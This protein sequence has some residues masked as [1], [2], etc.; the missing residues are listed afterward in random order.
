MHPT[1]LL[2][3]QDR[4]VGVVPARSGREGAA[5][6]VAANGLGVDGRQPRGGRQ[7]RAGSAVDDD[8]VERS[9]ELVAR[10]LP[11]E[12][13][14]APPHDFVHE[15]VVAHDLVEEQAHEVRRAPVDV[16]PDGAT[17]RQKLH[18]LL[19]PRCEHVQVRAEPIAPAVVVG[20]CAHHPP[21]GGTVQPCLV[22]VS[23]LRPERGIEVDQIDPPLEAEAA[24]HIERV[25]LHETPDGAG[26][27]R[28][29]DGATRCRCPPARRRGHRRR[30]AKPPGLRRHFD[31]QRGLAHRIAARLRRQSPT[32]AGP[33]Q[34]RARPAGLHASL[35]P[36]PPTRI[37][38][39]HW[40]ERAYRARTRTRK[41]VELSHARVPLQAP[42]EISCSGRT[43]V[44]PSHRAHIAAFRSHSSPRRHP[45]RS[46]ARRARRTH[47][48][49]RHPHRSG[50]AHRCALS[51]RPRARIAAGAPRSVPPASRGRRARSPRR[52]GAG[53]P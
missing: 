47:R 38:C 5:S 37:V 3:T 46:P 44:G 22:L 48:P 20:P 7:L 25:A 4:F 6:L 17:H 18:E 45:A 27:R 41:R 26:T 19:E 29:N 11:P 42:L 40:D 43:L 28:A 8:R 24:R 2:Q 52:R 1:L 15:R 53:V 10:G 49:A 23:G 36:K 34:A 32:L 35:G 33:N 13:R 50:Q 12:V 21:V 14:R 39:R 9:P 31:R 30:R 16:H 51:G